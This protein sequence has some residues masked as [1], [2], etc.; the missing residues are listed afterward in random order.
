[1]HESISGILVVDDFDEKGRP[2]RFALLTNDEDKY[3][4]ESLVIS[5]SLPAFNRKNVA[6][7]GKVKIEKGVK[8]FLADSIV[9]VH[10]LKKKT[11]SVIERVKNLEEDGSCSLG[12]D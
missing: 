1:M 4:V 12:C 8:F 11:D 9:E 2:V 10:F 3:I 6:M 7:T 5:E